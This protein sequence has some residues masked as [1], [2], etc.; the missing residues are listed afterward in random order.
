MCIY[1]GNECA[2]FIIQKCMHLDEKEDLDLV[3]SCLVFS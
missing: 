3:N 1:H 2:C